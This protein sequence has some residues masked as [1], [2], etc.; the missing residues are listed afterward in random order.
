[1]FFVVVFHVC[2]HIFLYFSVVLVRICS[3]VLFLIAVL[4]VFVGVFHPYFSAVCPYLQLCFF[5]ICSCVSSVFVVVFCSIFVVVFRSYFSV[6][7][8]PY[9]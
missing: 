4:F 1:M 8:R 9:L 5:Y 7:F 2:S 6:M 3:C